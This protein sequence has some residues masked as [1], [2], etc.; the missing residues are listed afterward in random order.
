MFKDMLERM[1][2]GDTVTVELTREGEGKLRA[3]V[4]F[5]GTAVAQDVPEDVQSM[6]Q[7]LSQPLVIRNATAADMEEEIRAQVLGF[8]QANREL[9][10]S[11]DTLLATLRETNKEARAKMQAGKD[12]PTATPVQ[13][14]EASTPADAAPAAPVSQDPN[15]LFA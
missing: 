15:N 4:Q 12:K 10:R 8:T 2:T 5:H 13:D 11:V 3:I 1:A 14:D 7:R 9:A 6:R